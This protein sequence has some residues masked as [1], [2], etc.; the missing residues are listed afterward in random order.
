M[1]RQGQSLLPTND[2]QKNNSESHYTDIEDTLHTSPRVQKVKL[3]N[4]K[5]A[6][7]VSVDYDPNGH[8]PSI[9]LALQ[10]P[11]FPASNYI[12][13]CRSVPE[14][15]YYEST[16]SLDSIYDVPFK[17]ELPTRLFSHLPS[18]PPPPIPTKPKPPL[19]RRNPGTKLSQTRQAHS[20]ENLLQPTS[21]RKGISSRFNSQDSILN[22]S[23]IYEELNEPISGNLTVTDNRS[24][25]RF[26]I[27]SHEALERK[28]RDL[29]SERVGKEYLSQI[30][31]PLSNKPAG[32]ILQPL[33]N[34]PVSG[35]NQ[36][37]T[38]SLPS[39][40]RP[41]SQTSNS[42]YYQPTD[43]P[44]YL[45]KPKVAFGVASYD[46]PFG[47]KFPIPLPL[48][49][50]FPMPEP[51]L[52]NSANNEMEQ[53]QLSSSISGSKDTLNNSIPSS[54]FRTS[55]QTSNSTFYQPNNAP[56]YKEKSKVAF[57]VAAYD[58]PLAAEFPSPQNPFSLAA[59]EKTNRLT[60]KLEQ[61]K[62][63]SIPPPPTPAPEQ[64]DQ[65][66][67]KLLKTNTRMHFVEHPQRANKSKS[68]FH[69]D[70]APLSD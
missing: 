10:N 34:T 32:N 21:K 12:R 17:Y 18:S 39:P 24:R 2:L 42:T 38:D 3:R 48:S 13:N 47:A 53:Q 16:S 4:G 49:S 46:D 51:A 64:K 29:D 35:S 63:P 28:S 59:K 50:N 30:Q 36:S 26:V 57:G 6:N 31:E 55:S 44:F 41:L 56:F 52:H 70:D 14:L 5:K 37:P 20:Q 22:P 58:D 69:L 67:T 7:D 61:I 66:N 62:K 68:V 11:V 19:P 1:H 45:K 60:E 54:P 43:V 25:T 8:P 40:Y 9:K 33:P 65:K 23:R 27:S 15:D